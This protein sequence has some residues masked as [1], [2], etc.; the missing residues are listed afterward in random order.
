[1][2]DQTAINIP[3]PKYSHFRVS[4]KLM[5]ANRLKYLSVRALRLYLFLSLRYPKRN[6]SDQ[7]LFTDSEIEQYVGISKDMVSQARADLSRAKLITYRHR[8][9]EKKA[10]YTVRQDK[11]KETCKLEG[12]V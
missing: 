7:L 5:R 4:K 8:K 11:S 10:Y 12:T 2:I 9:G 1:M 3:T 6:A